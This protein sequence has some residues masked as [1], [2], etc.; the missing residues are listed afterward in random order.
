MLL[1]TA[2]RMAA[3]LLNI[4]YHTVFTTFKA[5]ITILSIWIFGIVLIPSMLG[6][7]Y[8]LYCQ[9]GLESRV[10]AYGYGIAVPV[11]CVLFL[12]FAASAFFWSSYEVEEEP[13]QWNSRPCNSSFIQSFS[14]QYSSYQLFYYWMRLLSS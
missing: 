14:L 10:L 13:D 7:L 3:I 9:E 4:P 1:I 11:Y 2:D 6:F 12:F 8:A 5:K